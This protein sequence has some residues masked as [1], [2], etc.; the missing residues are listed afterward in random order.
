VNLES[1]KLVA[2]PPQ[3]QNTVVTMGGF[4]SIVNLGISVA[5]VRRFSYKSVEVW[6]SGCLSL[7]E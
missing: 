1:V 6:G 7:L 4:S 5:V 2:K 3:Y